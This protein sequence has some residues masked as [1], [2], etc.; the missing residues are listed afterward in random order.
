MY[1]QLMYFYSEYKFAEWYH[2]YCSFLS[3]N[4]STTVLHTQTGATSRLLAPKQP[5]CQRIKFLLSSFLNV[6]FLK[7]GTWLNRYSILR[8]LNIYIGATGIIRITNSRFYS[9]LSSNEVSHHLRLCYCSCSKT[10]AYL[11]FK[12]SFSLQLALWKRHR[13]IFHKI[14]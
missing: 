4:R 12:T 6:E 1:L 11:F 10:P 8:S 13:W 3:G 2:H 5:C 7:L 14:Y 9:L